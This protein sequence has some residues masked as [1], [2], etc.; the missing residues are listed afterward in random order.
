[1][2]T[3]ADQ[4]VVSADSTG[5]HQFMLPWTVARG[6]ASNLSWN[7]DIGRAVARFLVETDPNQA[8]AA[9]DGLG[10]EIEIV[11]SFHI[12]DAWRTLGAQNRAGPA[13]ARLQT[14]YTLVSAD[15]SERAYGFTLDSIDPQNQDYLHVLARRPEFPAGFADDVALPYRNGRGEGVDEFLGRAAAYE[16]RVLAVPWL[17]KYMRTERDGVRLNYVHGMSLDDSQMQ[18]FAADMRGLGKDALVSMVRAVQ[19]KVVLLTSGPEGFDTY[20]LVLPDHRVILWRFH[21]RI[22]PEKWHDVELNLHTKDC[23]NG[24]AMFEACA[25]TIVGTDGVLKN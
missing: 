25:G 11:F 10:G 21:S 2:M 15:I 16:A 4:S 22:Y 1:M 23:A 13:L 14:R 12:A 17:V 7:A 6:A 18:A 9:G 5:L 3:F 24:L 8:R 19:D 20:W